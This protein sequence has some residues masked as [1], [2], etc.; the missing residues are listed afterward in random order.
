MTQEYV[1]G[2]APLPPM[3]PAAC[4]NQDMTRVP[5]T[6]VSPQG[7]LGG[8]Q[9][10]SPP[11]ASPPPPQPPLGG[12]SA[13]SYV[14]QMYRSSPHAAQ[15][16]E[17]Q[18]LPTSA[19]VS[20]PSLHQHSQAPPRYQWAAGSTA[21]AST[22][23]SHAGA[24]PAVA[25]N[26]GSGAPAAPDGSGGIGSQPNSQQPTQPRAEQPISK[27]KSPLPKLNIRGGDPTTLTRII[28]VDPED[29]HSTQHMVDRS[30]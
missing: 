20:E 23:L 25:V 8:L 2:R 11:R 5:M 7:Y 26:T 16:V 10:G 29:S 22:S 28:R 30:F 17:M 18:P 4:L 1:P 15:A 19:G 27:N 21:G 13:W 12:G 6:P 24:F 9:P 14:R 3:T